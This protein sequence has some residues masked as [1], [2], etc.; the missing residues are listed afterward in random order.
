MVR[1]NKKRTTM[2]LKVQ[3]KDDTVGYLYLHA[4]RA[5]GPRAASHARF[6]FMIL[7]PATRALTFT[8]TSTHP[9]RPLA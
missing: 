4:I 5:L 8:S 6:G 3:A 2:K 7:S 1:R 9:A